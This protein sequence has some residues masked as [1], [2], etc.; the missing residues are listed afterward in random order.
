[1]A[2]TAS[3]KSRIGTRLRQARVRRGI[4]LDQASKGTRI[5]PRYLHALERDASL[6]AFPAPVYAKAFLREY[7]QWLGLDPKPLVDSFVEDHPEP[8]QPLVLPTPLQ[9]L[10]GR[11][12]RRSLPMVSIIVLLT[13]LVVSTRSRTR[14]PAP[15]PSAP[16]PAVSAAP[17]IGATETS[18]QPVPRDVMLALRIV[19]SP[20]WVKVTSDRRV[21]MQ[22]I[23]QPGFADTFIAERRLDLWVGNAGAVRLTLNGKQ[24]RIPREAGA[25][26]QVSFIRAEKGLRLVPY[27]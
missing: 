24:L 26:Y 21:V 23:L 18:T 6:D 25:I 15:V 4:G 10:P 9:K 27:Q 12:A 1:V 11:W 14:P 8:A 13:L 22:T 20:C 5:R 3:A 2:V 7:A 16:S 17:V 19:E